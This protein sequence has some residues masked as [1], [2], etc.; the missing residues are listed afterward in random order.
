MKVVVVRKQSNEGLIYIIRS[1]LGRMLLQARLVM[2]VVKAL[3][4][5]SQAK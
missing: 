3:G 4:V 2:F 5:T 1:K